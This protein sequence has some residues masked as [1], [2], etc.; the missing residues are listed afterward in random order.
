MFRKS[1]AWIAILGLLFATPYLFAALNGAA[2]EAPCSCC[3]DACT[4][5]N[6]VCDASGCACGDGGECFCTGC[7][8]SCCD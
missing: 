8:A 2:N 7:A 6:C 4:C 1:L 3:G 5:V